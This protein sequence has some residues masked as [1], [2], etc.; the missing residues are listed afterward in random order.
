MSKCI[1]CKRECLD[2]LF[3][4]QGSCLD[5]YYIVQQFELEKKYNINF[6]N[7]NNSELLDYKSEIENKIEHADLIVK[8]KLSYLKTLTEYNNDF[9][10][11]K[12]VLQNNLILF[13]ENKQKINSINQEIINRNKNHI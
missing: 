3:K 5:C 10:E 4:M 13:I 6:T 11:N 7:Y 8:E 1:I 2:F 12:I 9:I